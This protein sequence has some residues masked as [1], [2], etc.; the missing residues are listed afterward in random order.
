[1]GALAEVAALFL[2]LGFSAFGGPGAHVALM[3]RE[4]VQRRGWLD[5]H[6]F[7][8]LLGACNLLPGPGS[9]QLAMAL[10]QRRAGWP[11]L[12]VAGLCFLT[13]AAALSAG[14][15][16][17]YLR[18]GSLPQAQGVLAGLKPVVLALLALALAKLV[19]AAL[20][21]PGQW[22]GAL[23]AAVLLLGGQPPLAALLA[24]GL[25]VLAWR[26]QSARPALGGAA[27]APWAQAA[28]AVSGAP[29]LA[30]LSAVF[31]KLGVV[32]FG[33]GYVLLAFLQSELVEQRHWLSP[34]QLM[35]A[36]AAGQLTPGP[37]FSAAAFIGFLLRG[38]AGAGL[39]TAAIFLPSFAMVAALGALVP[40]LAR[41][42]SARAL[43]DGVN[44][45][46][47]TALALLC[48]TLGRAALG[49][50]WA[51]ALA[52]AAFLALR[53]GWEP[54]LLMLAGA[55]AGLLVAGR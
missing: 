54:T 50:P 10:G 17:S 29:S 20:R 5:A 24:G 30:A 47:W 35:D 19:P 25:L 14:L 38:W 46:A 1:M 9:T 49:A 18:W 45:S 27:L 55:L 32:I 7:T 31:L 52:L 41:S 26:R 21:K 6:E 13:P 16:W 22:L 11:G 34:A 37:L 12:W 36:V 53:R 44:A 2:R 40:R 8:D 4:C 43:L 15:A 3:Q 42:P 28:A 39:A 48:V 33:S 51:W 23:G